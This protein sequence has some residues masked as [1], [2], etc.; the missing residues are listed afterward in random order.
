MAQQYEAMCELLLSHGIAPPAPAALTATRDE[1]AEA[2]QPSFG[3]AIH[4]L[5]IFKTY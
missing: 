5:A 3:Q 2:G 1:N 4:I